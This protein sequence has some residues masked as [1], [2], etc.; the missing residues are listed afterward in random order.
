[1]PHGVEVTHVNLN[2]NC[3]EGL[4]ADSLRAFSVHYHPEAAPGPHDARY[5]FAEFV[6]LMANG[7]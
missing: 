6:R 1:L 2:D 5:V 7:R 3:V 4:R